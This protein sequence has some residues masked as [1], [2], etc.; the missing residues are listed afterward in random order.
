MES[1]GALTFRTTEVAASHSQSRAAVG[2]DES[3][4]TDSSDI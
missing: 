2:P 1:L 4:T 3:L